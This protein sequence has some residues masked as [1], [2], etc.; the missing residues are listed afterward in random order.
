MSEIQTTDRIQRRKNKIQDL[1]DEGIDPYPSNYI[2]RD[3]I[4]SISDDNLDRVEFKIAGRI[5]GI[6][7]FKN[8]S[9]IDLE[10]STG[11][12]EIHNI[13]ESGPNEI[14]DDHFC[15]GDLVGFSGNKGINKNGEFCLVAFSQELLSPAI[16]DLPEKFN[17]IKDD[18][19]RFKHREIEMASNKE[20]RD[21]F[22]FRSKVIREI[23]NFLEKESFLEVETPILQPIYGGATARPFVTYHNALGREF[24][25]RISSELYLKRYLVGGLD[26]VFHIGKSF[27]NEGISPNH[28][29]EFTMVEFFGTCQTESAMQIVTESLINYLTNKLNLDSKFECIFDYD[30]KSDDWPLSRKRE[31][32]SADAWEMYINGIEIASCASDLNDPQEQS[33][34]FLEGSAVKVDDFTEANPYDQTYIESL[35]Y[36]LMPIAGVGIG[37][38]RL[39]MLLSGKKSIREVTAFPAMR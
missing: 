37:I 20:V 33:E 25:L 13:G 5:V 28:S 15:V 7:K 10:D 23:R 39:V 8:I 22:V 27:R 31:D 4:K 21:L 2:C 34:R 19:L 6:R 12:I 32:G 26:K 3:F 29:P 24:Y 16:R 14:D 17:G 1:R 18:E 11:K 36:G 35:E 38:D 9:F 30:Q